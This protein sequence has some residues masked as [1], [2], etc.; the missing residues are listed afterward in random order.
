MSHAE[1]VPQAAKPDPDCETTGY[2]E[3]LSSYLNTVS[4][5][6][7]LS[8]V[9][10]RRLGRRAGAGCPRAKEK[11]IEHN[12]RL[13]VHVSKRYRGLGVEFE[14]LVQEGTLGLIRAAEKFEPEL[15]YKFS[16]YA[17]WWIRQSAGRAV[18][19]KARSVR[20]PV[21]YQ[22][23]LRSL[24]D[25]ELSLAMRLG[26]EPSNQEIAGELAVGP[27]KVLEMKRV[28][29]PVSSLDAPARDTGESSDSEA[30][31]LLHTLPDHKDEAPESVAIFACDTELIR[32]RMATLSDTE[33][34]V[35]T[36]RYG[37]DDGSVWT[38]E[39]VADE[40]EVKREKVRR[41]QKRAEEKLRE[42]LTQRQA[43]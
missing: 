36:R 40:L 39:E 9:E 10:E 31:G 12:L 42:E 34:F 25:A 17:T 29:R 18:F 7:V 32:R 27:D 43:G 5:R 8:F 41:Y 37:L 30:P 38:L 26:R 3:S 15:G 6:P 11:L 22:E 16:T 4:R 28:R 24:R 35:L 1:L 2:T 19:N 21:H 23:Q 33:R 14:E 13:V 20:I